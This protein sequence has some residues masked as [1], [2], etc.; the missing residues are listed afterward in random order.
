[1]RVDGPQVFVR[2]K[3]IIDRCSKGRTAPAG[4]QANEIIDG[5]ATLSG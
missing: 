1:M 2:L 3:S 4:L 5:C